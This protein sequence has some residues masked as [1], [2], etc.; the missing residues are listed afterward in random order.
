MTDHITTLDI[1]RQMV[2]TAG[3]YNDLTLRLRM[4]LE[5]RDLPTLAMLGVVLG[6]AKADP[7][8]LQQAERLGVAVLPYIAPKHQSIGPR[9]MLDHGVNGYGIHL[10]HA[11]GT[12]VRD[13]PY[14][15]PG[16]TKRDVFARLHLMAHCWST[17]E[18]MFDG[19]QL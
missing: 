14:P 3:T 11:D 8:T 1:E 12:G 17:A 4:Q 2:R 6:H 18:S 13:W 10:L 15:Q 7:Y 5:A 19:G 16:A 9:I